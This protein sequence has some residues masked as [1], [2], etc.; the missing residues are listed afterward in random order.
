MPAGGWPP[1]KGRPVRAPFS[2]SGTISSVKNLPPSVSAGAPLLSRVPGFDPRRVP[3]VEH[4]GVLSVVPVERLQPEALRRRFDA[5]PA[6]RPEHLDDAIRTH[7]GPT[8]DAAVLVPVVLHPEP[9]LL[10]TLRTAHLHD[11]AGQVAFPGGRRDDTDADP[12]STALREAHEEIGLPPTC[13]EVLGQLPDYVTATGYRVVPVVGLVAPGFTLAL[14]AF[15]VDTAF[16]VPLSWLT[17]PANHRRHLHRFDDGRERAFWSM[18]WTDPASRREFFIWGA[19]AAM[20]RNFHGFL[21][22]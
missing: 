14:D 9:A 18:P 6:W 10:L 16:E 13:V 21:S 3:Q 17:D 11:H 20:I 12:V 2:I 19:T 5:P 7:P 15:E 8:R 22:A 4:E 1:G